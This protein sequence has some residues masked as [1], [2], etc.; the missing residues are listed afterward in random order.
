MSSGVLT[1]RQYYAVMEEMAARARVSFP[2]FLCFMHPPGHGPYIISRFHM[3]LAQRVQD[4]IEGRSPPRQAVSVPP[5]HGKS[6]LLSV[7]AVAW[8]MAHVPGINIALTGFSHTLL[9]DFVAEVRQLMDTPRYK[10]LFPGITPLFGHNRQ[11]TAWYNN[12]SIVMVKSCGNK[13]TGRRIDWLIIDDA[14]SGRE[15][16]ESAPARERL[17][18]WYFADCLTR[19][20]PNAKVFIIGTRWHPEDL[21]G[22]L[23][24]EEYVSELRLSGNTQEV[25]DVINLPAIAEHDP[26][27]GETDWIGREPGEVLFPEQRDIRFLL[28]LKAAM[29]AYEWDSQYRGKP[30]PS[31]SGQADLSKFHRVTIDDVPDNIEWVRGWDLALTEK[32]Q[33]DYSC[34]A[35]CAYDKELDELYIVGMYRKRLVWPKLKKQI[36]EVAQ[37]DKREY[38]INRMGLEAVSGF[39]IG[40]QELR[41]D[42]LGIVNVEKR[43]PPR[44]SKLMRAQDW[45]NMVEAGRVHVVMGTWVKDFFDELMVFP[46]GNHDDQIDAISVAWEC[47]TRGAK[48]LYA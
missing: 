46:D 13:F 27:R 6:R 3:M 28:G 14:H 33:S 1:T 29:P 25:F 2:A 44:G 39:E 26:D 36:I 45:L 18:T 48:L 30:R 42:L 17:K 22:E 19:L 15:E 11:D 35:L 40:L 43:N 21:I 10:Y 4:I 9:C 38:G 12:G 24:K 31:A 20:S 23:T 34:G 47:L 32:Q 8:V 41:E 5:Q 7:R 16:A 37:Q